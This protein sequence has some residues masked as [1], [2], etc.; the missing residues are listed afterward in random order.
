V[1]K[2]MTNLEAELAK[3]KEEMRA[4]RPKAELLASPSADGT[5]SPAPKTAASAQQFSSSPPSNGA[6]SPPKPVQP[7]QP[8]QESQQQ[9][10][11][12]AKGFGGL[13]SLLTELIV[14]NIH[15]QKVVIV[16]ASS[17]DRTAKNVADYGS[18]FGYESAVSPNSWQCIDFK[19]ATV[20][21]SSYSIQSLAGRGLHLS[22]WVV[23][24]STDD[25]DWVSVDRRSESDALNGANATGTFWTLREKEVWQVRLRQTEANAAGRMAF[26]LAAFDVFGVLLDHKDEGVFTRLARECGGNV[27]DRGLV[28]CSARS[29]GDVDWAAQN[30]ADPSD[31]CFFCSENKPDQWICYDFGKL[32]LKPTGYFLKT[33]VGCG[34]PREWVVEAS[35]DG[36]NWEKFSDGRDERDAAVSERFSMSGS[37]FV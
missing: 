30:A 14:G 5:V 26:G 13:L 9:P 15:E 37:G 23:E 11:G 8:Q 1:K 12:K 4:S 27:H 7:P 20:K 24:G 22:G 3:L 21:M 29:C 33:A 17:N 2:E 32:R 35:N 31:G 36:E 10:T 6:A 18:A 25:K 16:S 34:D 28:A 19:T